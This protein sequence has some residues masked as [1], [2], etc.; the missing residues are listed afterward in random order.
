MKKFLDRLPTSSFV[1]FIFAIFFFVW[2]SYQ[3]SLAEQTEAAFADVIEI[4]DASALRADELARTE[5]AKILAGGKLTVTKAPTDP[6]TGVTVEDAIVLIR[7]V[8]MYQYTTDEEYLYIQY[9]EG[10]EPNITGVDG[11]EYT[12][13]VLP[14]EYR[15]AV[16]FGD[17]RL[18]EL[19]I[20]ERYLYELTEYPEEVSAPCD[21]L[22]VT[23]LPE[24]AELPEL[25]TSADGY[26]KISRSGGSPSAD[27]TGDGTAQAGTD[28]DI[29]GNIRISYKYLTA[30]QFG[31]RL[32]FL[33]LQK[34]GVLGGA[35]SDAELVGD[36][37]IQETNREAAEEYSSTANGLIIFGV[38][39]M[40]IAVVKF[41]LVNRKRREG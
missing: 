9:S 16:F 31:D 22:T 20:A 2:A 40:V 18:G 7:E 38:V 33:G 14:E 15:T 27:G 26:Y 13:P 32:Q 1:L 17:V 35:D 41:I 11:K 21:F 37:D 23:E 6:L 5:G 3:S 10:Q 30:E 36:D 28:E 24:I 25:Q 4:A 8:E 12:N 34:N 29:L 39:M 19:R